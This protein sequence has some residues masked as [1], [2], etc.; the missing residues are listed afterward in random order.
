M[1][2]AASGLTAGTVD[3]TCTSIKS[4]NDSG[5]FVTGHSPISLMIFRTSDFSNTWYEGTR[6]RWSVS[7][8]FRVAPLQR[9]DEG[10]CPEEDTARG[11][12]RVKA[13]PSSRRRTWASAR[14][15]SSPLEISAKT[16]MPALLRHDSL[17]RD[18]PAYR[19]QHLVFPQRRIRRVRPSRR[20]F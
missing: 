5:S 17:L 18:T 7:M 13:L 10:G 16:H 12:L 19:A 3:D 15:G 2:P 11:R 1:E 20:V 8:L 6:M 9:A 4:S 14:S